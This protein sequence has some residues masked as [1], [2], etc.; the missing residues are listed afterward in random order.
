[1]KLALARQYRPHSF[2]EMVGQEIVLRALKNALDQ[3]RLHHAYLFT[4]TRGVG[5]TTLARIL[6]KCFNCEV[7]ISSSPCGQ[8]MTCQEIDEGRF[9][10]LI[11]VDAASRTKVE[12][13][14]ELLENVQYLPNRGRYKI[15][16]IDEVHMLSNHSF[17]AL[18]KTLE[19]PPSH[20]IFLF[21]TTDPQ[22]LPATVLSRCLQFHLWRVPVKQIVEHLK[23]ILQKE[24]ATFEVEALTILAQAA[25]GSLR[26]ALSLLD[27]AISF[28]NH[29]VTLDGVRL[30]LGI[31]KKDT[32]LAL[33]SAISLGNVRSLLQHIEVLEEQTLDFSSLL[34]EFL[35]LLHQVTIAQLAPEALEEGISGRETIIKL[36]NDTS[37]EEIQLYYQIALQGQRDLSFSPT[38]KMG[39]EMTLL[40]MIAFQ[41]VRI[42]SIK[43]VE[44]IQRKAIEEKRIETPV[45]A[46]KPAQAPEIT[47]PIALREWDLIVEKLN[48][49]GLTKAL[50]E[51]CVVKTF[52]SDSIEL[53]LDE[54]Q[55]PLYNK[56][57]EER[58]QAAVS[59]Y[60]GRNIRLKIVEGGSTALTP[61]AQKKQHV[62]AAVESTRQMVEVD[63]KLQKIMQS[64]DAKIENITLKENE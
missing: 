20:V 21:A 1:M 9:V 43:T 18:L 32:L 30:M 57:Y 44:K 16:L 14:R 50:A 8:C 26:D 64:F 31:A 27:Q 22:K 60:L 59:Q 41:P 48:L 12:D 39:F 37:Q 28:S 52:G 53:I 45:P 58:L 6:A 29:V 33:L 24:Q 7:G 63:E 5:K 15:Y 46:E 36:A 62:T 42:E 40:R 38:P 17:N 19:E 34:S 13:T 61:A 4:G 51:H 25:D 54:T 10:D 47:A 2:P 55:K 49:S 3:K 23:T 11:E 35:T 56:R